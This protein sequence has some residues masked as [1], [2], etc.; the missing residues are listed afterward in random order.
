MKNLILSMAAAMAILSTNA[1]DYETLYV[2][3][4]DKVGAENNYIELTTTDGD[5]YSAT[6]NTFTN[7]ASDLNGIQVTNEDWSTIYCPMGWPEV[8]LDTV[9]TFE[10]GG[11]E[12]GWIWGWTLSADNYIFFQ[13][14]TGKFVISSDSNN[15]LTSSSVRDVLTEEMESPIYYNLQGVQVANPQNGIYVKKQGKEHST[16]PAGGLNRKIVHSI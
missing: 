2:Y 11:T 1:Q 14:S 16:F 4:Y 7:D 9:L 13:K 10:L 5:M 3:A 12:A 8:T 15:P 6:G